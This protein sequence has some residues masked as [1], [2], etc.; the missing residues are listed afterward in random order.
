[1]DRQQDQLPGTLTVTRAHL[2]PQTSRQSSPQ[3]AASRVASPHAAAHHAANPHV[4]V[5]GGGWAGLAAALELTTLGATVTVLERARTLGGRA[6]ALTDDNRDRTI[7]LRLDNGQHI[8]L[9]AY[10]TCLDL[11]QRVGV[12]PATALLRLPLQI[13]YADGFALA[14]TPGGRPWHLLAGLWQARSIP[15]GERARLVRKLAVAAMRGWRCH[16]ALTVAQ[17]LAGEPVQTIDRIWQ[18]LCISALNTP[19]EEASAQVFLNVLRDALLSGPGSSDMLVPRIDFGALFAEPAANWL[20]RHGGQVHLGKPVRGLMRGASGWNVMTTPDE[21]EVDGIVLATAPRDASRLING[22]A[23][24]DASAVLAREALCT[25]LAAL[26]H[27]PITTVYLPA[28]GV[29]LPHPMLALRCDPASGAFGQFLF[30]RGQLSAPPGSPDHEH[31]AIVI[32]VAD[33]AVQRPRADLAAAVCH[34]LLEEL[35]GVVPAADL[36]ACLL[37]DKALVITEKQATFR[38]RP[39][40]C[41]PEN[42]TGLPGLV[43]AGDYTAGPYPATLES[44]V[45]SGLQAAH[46]LWTQLTGDLPLAGR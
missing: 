29:R 22:I 2:P 42:A 5:I 6:R 1:M 24:T 23:L 20:A 38:S 36:Q 35:R 34:Q 4:A 45:R 3:V 28:P 44:A 26:T 14:A 43:L 19:I 9:G 27:A 8:L 46:T 21:L 11:M 10:R 16:D 12:T 17:W 13:R 31:W 32:S 33:D 15:L 30:D 41:R 39:G 7:R 37:P 40:I 25:Q 18:P